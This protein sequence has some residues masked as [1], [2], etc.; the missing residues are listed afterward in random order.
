MLLYN[1]SQSI[2]LSTNCISLNQLHMNLP[3]RYIAIMVARLYKQLEGHSSTVPTVHTLLPSH[4][5]NRNQRKLTIHNESKH[6]F[7]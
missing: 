3:V 5:I 4:T 1:Y 7:P 6:K 2:T